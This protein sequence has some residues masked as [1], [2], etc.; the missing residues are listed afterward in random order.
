MR[1][2]KQILNLVHIIYSNPNQVQDSED[3]RVAAELA[4]SSLRWRLERLRF[5][6]VL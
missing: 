6:C 3:E 4:V 1:M 5:P 2:L